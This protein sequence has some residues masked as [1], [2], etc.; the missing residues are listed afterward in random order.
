M[1]RQKN[2]KLSNSSNRE[3]YITSQ[4]K[5]SEEMQSKL[6]DRKGLRFK[7]GT[8][9]IGV[10]LLVGIIPLITAV[11]FNYQMSAETLKQRAH[12]QLVS[13]RELKVTQVQGMFEQTKNDISIM[14][15]LPTL[16]DGMKA[17]DVAFDE[18]FKSESYY[19]ADRVYDDIFNNYVTTYGYYDL[20]LIDM[21]GN[22]VY[23]QAKEADHGINLNE[24]SNSSL[25]LKTIYDKSLSDTVIQDFE[26]YSIS[27][28]PAAFIGT[29]IMDSDGEVIGVLVYQ[30]SLDKINDLL[31]DRSGLGESGETYIVG[32]DHLMR[33]DSRFFEE[34]TV[35]SK[36]V[37]TES[38]HAALEGKIGSRVID[39]YRG[40]AVLSA[41]APADIDGL[42]WVLIAEINEEEVMEKIRE[43]L[44]RSLFIIVVEIVAIVIVSILF[45]R[46]LVRP[47]IHLMELMSRAEK[48]NLLV[49]SDIKTKDE[50]QDLGESFNNMIQGQ[51]KAI[52]KVFENANTV[53]ETSEDGNKVALVMALSASNQATAVNE[54]TLTLGEMSKSIN[55]VAES[56][57]EIATNSMDVTKSMN[58]L[59]DAANDV[60]ENT[61]HTGET[62][63]EVTNSLRV[64][65]ESI[66]SVAK[67]SIDTSEEARNM[68][69]IAENGKKT[70]NNTVLEMDKI[71]KGME[72]L[73]MAVKGLGKAAIQ[74]GV[75]VEV[76]DDIAD[77]TNL[78]ALNAS[79]EAA[80]AGE[81]GKGFAVVASAIGALAEKSGEAT[82]DI[83][84]LIHKIQEEVENSVDTANSSA[85]QV[86]TGAVL[87]RNTGT[88]LDD[89]F[90]AIKRT[91]SLI[92]EIASETESQIAES[93]KVMNAIQSVND[94]SIEVAT[95][96]EEQVAG[97]DSALLNMENLNMLTQ[98]V[99]G[100]AE[101]QSAANEEI[102][103]SA[104]NINEMTKEIKKGTEDSAENSEKLTQFA[105]NLMDV[106]AAFKIKL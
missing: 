21:D 104:E 36:K 37:D 15:G 23:T 61:K 26:Y 32:S 41:Y 27:D 63:V 2:W 4:T 29:S 9:L 40:V 47:I 83:T 6:R 80:R 53:S 48:G 90:K 59:S 88:A 3:V 8:K 86:G 38:T 19:G 10:M 33:S 106:V 20:F 54:I 94:M 28:E 77:Q 98:S 102:L 31:L 101:E 52:Q 85:E 73:T 46:S 1:K 13:T 75:I 68:V 30:L 55:D 25:P 69:E 17:Y 67:S 74:I 43:K 56:M 100:A 99:A 105:G 71:N 82:K 49:Q 24:G 16:V 81:Q 45:S 95:A 42:D 7:L 103:A 84:E 93:Q 78:L 64:V 34:S 57:T 70:I 44:N 97:I 12:D 91:T 66:E 35:L 72:S 22:V 62:L 76:I 11:L 96:V 89:I 58:S 51:L 92:N 5:R 65:N 60:A 14:A 39:D 18:G 87:V 50:I 79:I